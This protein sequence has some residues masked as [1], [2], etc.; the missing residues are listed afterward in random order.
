MDLTEQQVIALA[1][2]RGES[3]RYDLLNLQDQTIGTLDGVTGAS[4]EF[5]IASTIRSGGSL[6]CRVNGV[7]WLSVRIQPWYTMEAEG[8][9][10]TWP[11]GV[12]IPASPGIQ[13][14][15]EGN[16]RTIDLYD[17]LQIL[18]QDRVETTYSVAPGVVV[19]TLIKG[20]LFGIGETRD[21]ITP[22]T[23][24]V[25]SAMVWEADTSKLQIINDLLASINY[26]SLWVDGYGVFQ[27]T[28]YQEPG[29]RGTAWV[30]ED[31]DQSIYS[32]DFFNDRDDFNVPNKVALVSTSTDTVAALTAVATNENPASPYSYNRRGRWI[33]TTEKDIEVA[34]QGTLNLMAQRRLAELSQVSS[35]FDISHALIPLNLNDAVKFVRSTEGIS[36]VGVVQKMSFGTAV[37]EQVKTTIREVTL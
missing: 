18:D 11:I 37:G 2:H 3:W 7:D 8:E 22:S 36:S 5:S 16:S 31:D 19:T 24:T 26:F 32:P 14:S 15:G 13:F 21:A 29:K 20:L 23:A 33:T 30:F 27:G 10:L 6:E 9:T 12:F 35:N 34:N 1:G 25:R 17:K 28:P 4:F